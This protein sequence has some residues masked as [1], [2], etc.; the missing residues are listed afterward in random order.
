[1]LHI[2][3][4]RLLGFEPRFTMDGLEPPLAL[5]RTGYQSLNL[6]LAFYPI[7]TD[8]LLFTRQLL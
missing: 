5:V 3:I 2:K 8:D 7:R 4:G 1:M 6:R